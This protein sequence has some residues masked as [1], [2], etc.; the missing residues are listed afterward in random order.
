MGLAVGD[1]DNIQ[2]HARMDRYVAQTEMLFDTEQQ[3]P[4]WLRKHVQF[5]EHVEYPNKLAPLKTRLYDAICGFVHP[6]EDDRGE[7]SQDGQFPEV[8]EVKKR[9]EEQEV[10]INEICNMLR[11]QSEIMENMSQNPRREK[12]E[13]EDQEKGE[14]KLFSLMAF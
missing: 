5:E 7:S 12:E 3:L 11:K 6:D 1:I 9:L 10:K 8:A 4:R 2:R 14:R 13:N